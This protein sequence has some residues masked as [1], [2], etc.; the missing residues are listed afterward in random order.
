VLAYLPSRRK[1][2][3]WKLGDMSTSTSKD[4]EQSSSFLSSD[5]GEMVNTDARDLNWRSRADK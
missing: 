4:E 1:G 2:A 5:R 3:E